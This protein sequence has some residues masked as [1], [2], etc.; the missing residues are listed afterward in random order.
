MTGYTYEKPLSDIGHHNYDCLK[1]YA[2]ASFKR[3]LKGNLF[4]GEPLTNNAIYE[5]ADWVAER[6][7]YDNSMNNVMASI[8][9]EEVGQFQD[10]TKFYD[11]T[12]Y[13]ENDDEEFI[14][15]C[16]NKIW[17]ANRFL[18]RDKLE[19]DLIDYCIDNGISIKKIDD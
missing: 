1:K 8:S 13:D 7:D 9:D 2:I 17:S 10:W 19:N 5:H 6:L 15:E 11:E 4:Y 12:D 18:I 14:E 3:D 16:K